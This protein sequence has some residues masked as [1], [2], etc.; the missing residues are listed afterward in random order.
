MLK[1]RIISF[2][3]VLVFAIPVLPVIQVGS[4]LYQ[5]QFSEE[6]SGH[7]L[8]LI[9]KDADTKPDSHHFIFPESAVTRIA[10]LPIGLDERFYSRQAD[11]IMTPP[12]NA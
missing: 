7:G 12:P 11:D 8:S 5:N 3:L 9:K 6:L 2:F 1:K 10:T 4:F